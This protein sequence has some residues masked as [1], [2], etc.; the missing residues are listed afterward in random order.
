MNA[1]INAL[2]RA[3]QAEIA[4]AAAA[5]GRDSEGRRLISLAERMEVERSWALL[6]KVASELRQER[7]EA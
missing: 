7:E 4:A 1:L 5:A 3:V 6:A 2:R